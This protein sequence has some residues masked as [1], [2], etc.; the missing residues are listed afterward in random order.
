M[1]G[2]PQG[3]NI[4]PRCPMVII[5]PALRSGGSS[6]SPYALPNYIMRMPCPYRFKMMFERAYAM[7]WMGYNMDKGV[8]DWLGR[9]QKHFVH[10]IYGEDDRLGVSTWK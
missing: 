4:Y 9:G 3:K 2:T 6:S 10:A 8:G 5:S 7:A 1:L